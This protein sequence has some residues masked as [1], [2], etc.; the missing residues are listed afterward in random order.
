MRYEFGLVAE[1][2]W[3][4]GKLN[5]GGGGGM[6]NGVMAQSVADGM[7]VGEGAAS[8]ISGLSMMSIG[9]TGRGGGMMMGGYPRNI[10]GRN[11][12][13]NITPVASLAAAAYYNPA[14]TMAGGSP[15]AISYQQ[16]QHGMM[17]HPAPAGGDASV[18]TNIFHC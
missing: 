2:G 9:R 15:V 16:Q 13:N 14:G 11:I 4:K 5:D 17:N 8:V 10:M 6:S 12:L 7:M 3:I 1:G 18:P